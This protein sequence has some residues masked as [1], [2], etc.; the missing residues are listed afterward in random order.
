[1]KLSFLMN[2]PTIYRWS[3]DSCFCAAISGRSDHAESQRALNCW[4]RDWLTLK[5]ARQNY[6][7]ETRPL[8]FMWRSW[9]AR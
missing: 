4:A 2:T 7:A 1:M 6:F 9:R 3:D 8:P 5:R